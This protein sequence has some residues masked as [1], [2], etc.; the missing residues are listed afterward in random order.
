[1]KKTFQN[2]ED[3]PLSSMKEIKYTNPLL[4]V[5]RMNPNTNRDNLILKD[6]LTKFL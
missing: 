3:N 1:M 5:T 2:T 6:E 4:D